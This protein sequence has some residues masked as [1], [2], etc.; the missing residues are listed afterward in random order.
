M[1]YDGD[2]VRHSIRKYWDEVGTKFD[3][4]ATKVDEIGTNYNP[5]VIKYLPTSPN[6]WGAV[7]AHLAV[8][9]C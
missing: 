6:T 5:E 9:V 8:Y 1:E 7:F 3:D 4:C 2:L